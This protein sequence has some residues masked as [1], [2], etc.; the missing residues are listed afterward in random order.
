[1]G[2][3]LGLM[4]SLESVLPSSIIYSTGPLEPYSIDPM[5]IA[6]PKALRLRYRVDLMNC[7]LSEYKVL[8][9]LLLL[10]TKSQ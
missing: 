8:G 10:L 5:G 1:M 4:A 3:A 7:K 2:H 9:V 6:K